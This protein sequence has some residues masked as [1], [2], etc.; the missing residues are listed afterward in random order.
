VKRILLI[1]PLVAVGLTLMAPGTSLY[2]ESGGGKRCTACHEMRPVYDL[3]S[4]SSHRNIGCEKCHGWALTTDIPFHTNNAARAYAH[5]RGD[6]PER[7]RLGNRFVLAMVSQC[8][9]CH[10][11]EYASWLSGPHSAT[12]ARIFLD[13]KHNTANMLIDDCLRCHGMHFADGVAALVSPIDRNGPWRLIPEDLADAPSMPCTACHEI[14]REGQ[15]LNKS[16]AKGSVPGPAQELMRPALALYDRRTQQYVPVREL[17]L[18]AMMEG[19]RMV[20]LSMDQRQALCYQ[21]HAPISTMQVGSGDDR[22]G[23]GVHEGISCLAC[24][25]EH[26][27]RTR[28]SC[29]TCHPKMSNCGL[30]VEKMDTTFASSRSKHNI[31][32]VKCADCHTKGVPK[33]KLAT[34]A[35]AQ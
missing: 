22:T 21:C 31:H 3:W 12:Y 4:N 18:P 13:K 25:A 2:F 6:L 27:E 14:H 28:A 10:R 1:A 34:V 16:G 9:S 29:A 5:L 32:W 17:P 15:P 11:Q 20:K 19:N 7:I 35:L 24:H 23:I 8:G 33:K 30:D 26:G